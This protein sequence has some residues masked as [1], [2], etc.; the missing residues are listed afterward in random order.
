M[1]TVI[2]NKSIREFDKFSFHEEC[3]LSPLFGC[4]EK[5]N[6][7]VLLKLKVNYTRNL[8]NL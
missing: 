1:E 8:I 3:R 4:E 7:V 2:D 5:R 6:V